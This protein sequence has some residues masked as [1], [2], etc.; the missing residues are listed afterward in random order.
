MPDLFR[1]DDS[2]LDYLLSQAK[3][4]TDAAAQKT[5][6]KHS[7]DTAPAA[8]AVQLRLDANTA[9][10]LPLIH[11]NPFEKR[12]PTIKKKLPHEIQKEREQTT[13]RK[14]FNMKAPVLTDAIKNDL[15][16]LQLR[17]VLDPK[18]FY[19]KEAVGKKLPKYF[20]MGTVVE[21]ASEFYS[22]RLTR[23]ERRGNLVVFQ[24][25]G[26][27]IFIAGMSMEANR[28]TRSS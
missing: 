12:D 3:D 24:A 18:R 4:E 19:K 6:K 22:A 16:V 1:T 13:G 10:E 7:K 5:E 23:K 11:T 15:R 20:E 14:W 21:D 28:G 26:R 8:L 2:D 9:S 17:G 25:K 27:S